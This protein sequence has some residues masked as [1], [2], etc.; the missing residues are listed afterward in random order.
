MTNHPFDCAVVGGGLAGLTAAVALGAA[1]RS[2]VHIAAPEPSGLQDRR[3]TAL[4][5]SSVQL[6][7][8]LGVWSAC[9]AHAAPLTAIRLVDGMDR[10]FRAPDLV[11]EAGEI[12]LEAL[13]YNIENGRLGTALAERLATLPVERVADRVRTITVGLESAELLL[14][15][16]D[17]R[18]VR[19]VIAADGRTSRC[20]DAAGI[21]ASSWRYD[22]T[23]L[24]C[25]V[26]HSREQ[27]GSSTEIHRPA[28]PLTTVPLATGAA[29]IVWVERPEVAERLMELEP[30]A[31]ATE[32]EAALQGLLGAIRMVGE[33]AAIAIAGLRVER[34]AARRIALVGEAAHA[35]PPIGAQ[36]L[37]LS[38][39][40]VGALVD[41]VS[42]EDGNDQDP[43]GPAALDRYD[44]S[45]RKDAKE[46]T[47]AVDLL[48]RSLLT[49]LWPLQL[50]RGLGL[51]ALKA[52]GPLRR[53]IM[54]RGLAPS[55]GLPSLMSPGPDLA[56][57][58][59]RDPQELEVR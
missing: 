42:P 53:D 41:A 32:L 11:F 37:N 2:T 52:I 51:H 3:T 18:A 36:G 8:R 27:G 31:F 40:D 12:G 55:T 59:S 54:R 57:A 19:L 47:M 45:R 29:S 49:S 6:L 16:G 35:F 44:A 23:A 50:A 39:R 10:L 43:G 38:L 26:S 21:T 22:Q 9:E 13:A 25:N 5:P 56:P 48:N 15:S 33:R 46:R 7:R 14:D 20:R 17:A 1:G 34:H 30:A 28:G 4:F 58:S 24:V